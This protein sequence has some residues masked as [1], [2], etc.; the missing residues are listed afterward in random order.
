MSLKS[1]RV[2]GIN[3]IDDS[4]L[5]NFMKKFE[6]I[7]KRPK[8]DKWTSNEAK[9]NFTSKILEYIKRDLPV[10]FILLGFPFKS[11]SNEKVIGYLPDM[12]EY[13][14]LKRIEDW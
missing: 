5:A 12:G 6:E 4:L 2:L 13:V 7:R 11:T 1:T 9:S 8:I 14:C 10:P 3:E